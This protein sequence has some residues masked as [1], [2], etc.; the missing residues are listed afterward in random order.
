MSYPELA[1][2][3]ERIQ[4]A[5]AGDAAS[6]GIDSYISRSW[7]RCLVEHEL[8][9]GEQRKPVIVERSQLKERREQ[10]E[11]LLS[12]ATTEMTNLYQQVAGSGYAIML[13]DADGIVLNYVGDPAFNDQASGSGLMNGALW[14]EQ[15]QGTN[16]MGTC[17]VE[18]KPVVVHHD[19]HFLAKNTALTCSAAPIRNPEG[20]LIAVLDASSASRM[21]QQH[22]MV[23]VNMSAQLI[24]NRIFLCA[25]RERY[26][27]R[28]HSRAE[29]V[30][31][32]GEGA[33]AFDGAG[34][35]LGANRSALFQLDLSSQNEITGRLI[36]EIFDIPLA[37]LMD[38]A[39]HQPFHPIALHYARD[40]KRFFA[41]VQR[42]DRE[43]GP[44][45]PER[46]GAR[47]QQR[48]CPNDP[49]AM[50]MLEFGDPRIAHNIRRAK[51]L[52]GREIPLLLYGETGTGKGLFAKA[53]HQY[54]NRA[55]RPFV[56]VNCAAIPETLIESELF[57]YKA[58][59]FTGASRQ[60]NRGKIVQANGGTLFLDEIGD[61]PLALQAR[62]L[63]VLEDKEIVPLG[64][65]TPTKVDINVVSATH[66]DLNQ[67]IAQGRFRED[68]YYR[69]HGMALTIPPLRERADK[70]RLI[71]HILRLEQDEGPPV[72]IEHDALLL[73]ME[74]DWPGN[75]RELCNA[76][77]TMIALCSNHCITIAD[78]PEEVRLR[79][80]GA[81][82]A[83]AQSDA[84]KEQLRNPLATAEYN[85]LMQELEAMRWNIA[86]VARK[87]NVSRNTLYRKMKRFGITPPR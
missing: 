5:V 61:M 40:G 50:D 9:P 71:E 81:V 43:H 66:R 17:L 3:I 28:F 14:S 75:V 13:T 6:S 53:L 85:I 18:R 57:G 39:I 15:A 63:R 31:T 59:A 76:L 44:A 78:L 47:R 33:L 72:H 74:Y 4:S 11:Q 54:S 49:S 51:K 29:F 58:G 2:H 79:N 38:Q 60:G 56:P 22:T 36:S 87:F 42:P 68:L 70:E 20:N 10:L 62:L 23:L 25:Y 82:P 83:N 80:S 69:L 30:S 35:I 65:E 41:M 52:V 21:A 67:L 55:D 73:M 34:R 48:A 27:A 19:D 45:R 84:L 64:S 24:E 77:R 37:S 32:L 86:K 26:I 8:D 12:I 1:S 16:G 46:P 7:R